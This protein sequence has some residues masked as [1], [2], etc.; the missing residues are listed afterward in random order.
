MTR[1]TFTGH[2]PARNDGL[3]QIDMPRF[4]DLPAAEQAQIVRFQRDAER[5]RAKRNRLDEERAL[6]GALYRVGG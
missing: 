2:E 4:A 3:R 1:A 5:H 6:Q